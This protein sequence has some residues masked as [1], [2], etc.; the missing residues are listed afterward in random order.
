MAQ[1][2]TKEEA[3]RAELR[4]EKKA[5]EITQKHGLS[6]VG[7]SC[8]AVLREQCRQMEATQ[9]RKEGFRSKLREKLLSGDV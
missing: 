8:I 4:L 5:L 6:C 1:R 3:A 7:Q 2:G 9:A